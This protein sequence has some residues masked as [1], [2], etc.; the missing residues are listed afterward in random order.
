LASIACCSLLGPDVL[1]WGHTLSGKYFVSIGY[2]EITRQLLGDVEVPSWKQIWNKF[3]WFKY[4]F[5]MWLVAHNCCPTW[6]NLCK[7]G[8]QGPSFCVLCGNGEDFVSHLFFHCSFSTQLWHLWWSAWGCS[9]WHASSLPKFWA[10]LGS[11]PSKAS[12]LH[13]AWIAGPSFI[14]WHSWL[15]RNRQIFQ[16]VSIGV[17]HLWWKISHSLQE[18]IQAKCELD[19]G[20]DPADLSICNRLNFHL[21]DGAAA[22]WYQR[23]SKQPRQQGKGR[24]NRDGHWTPH[25]VLKINT[26][27]F[28]Q[29]NPGPAGIGGVARCSS[30][31]VKLFFLVYKGYHTNNLMEA[32]AI[33]YVVEQCCLRGWR[34]IICEFDSQVVV[35]LLTS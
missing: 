20:M 26:D 25:G 5:F 32:Q 34:K 15:E 9:C 35:N 33:L 23:V 28:S 30:S 12:P 17:M 4:S 2:Q 13:A 6:D 27:G 24:V 31:E 11:A 10:R 3:S 22:Q 7:R 18:T 21:Q 14:L 8:F 29:G 1:A 16:D 19:G